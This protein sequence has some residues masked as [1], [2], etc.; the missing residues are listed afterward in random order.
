MKNAQRLWG[1]PLDSPHSLEPG[2]PWRLGGNEPVSPARHFIRAQLALQLVT[3]GTPWGC[4]QLS[5]STAV[6]LSQPP[7]LLGSKDHRVGFPEALQSLWTQGT[8]LGAVNKHRSVTLC[9]RGP[10]TPPRVA[11]SP[12]PE[13]PCSTPS[14][15]TLHSSLGCVLV[16]GQHPLPKSTLCPSPRLASVFIM[17]ARGPISLSTGS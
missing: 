17:E 16:P 13:Y 14:L 2:P 11:P 7:G 12:F 8:E 9:V 6:H 3:L 10:D 1:V 5:S 15:S 4:S